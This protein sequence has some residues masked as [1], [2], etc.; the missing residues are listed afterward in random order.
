MARRRS[1]GKC[2]TVTFK[3]SA[4]GRKIRPRS[5]WVTVKRCEGRKLRAHNRR[6]CRRGKGKSFRM[7]QFVKCR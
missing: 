1:S 7:R 5:A 2:T 4:K 3:R 6:Q